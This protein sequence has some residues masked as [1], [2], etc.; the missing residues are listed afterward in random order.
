MIRKKIPLSKIC[1]MLIG[2]PWLFAGAEVTNTPAGPI[3]KI[4]LSK[5]WSGHSVGFSLLT[6]PPY[7]YAAYYDQDRNLVVASRRLDEKIWT[8]KILPTKLEWDSHNYVTMA[9]DNSGNLH[10]SGN[11]HVVPLIYFRT[12]KPRDIATLTS[13]AML[14]E[15]EQRVTYPQFVKLSNGD[16]LFSYR[17]GRSGEGDTLWNA[18]NDKTGRWTRQMDKALFDG[19]SQMSS[20]PSAPLLGPDGYF[21][22]T[23]VWRDTADCS[24]CHD[25][26]YARTRDFKNWETASGEKIALP[27]RLSSPGVV[28]DAIPVKGGIINGSGR[29]GFDRENRLVITYHKYDKDGNTQLYNARREKNEW[30]FYQT[31]SWNYRWN[32]SGGGS[33]VFEVRHG[34][35]KMENGETT[36]TFAHPKEGSGKWR[37]DPDTLTP[38][39]KIPGTPA[40]SFLGSYLGKVVS[41]F[42]GMEV[43]RAGDLGHPETPDVQYLLR[44]ESLPPNRDAP[45]EKPW[46]EPS[47]LVLYRIGP[48]P[49]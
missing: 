2:L 39:G 46:P 32:F 41:D 30:K 14:G 27:I 29:I 8:K 37:L 26:S 44:W 22:M 5:V 18:W 15:R 45:R 9:V 31:T 3:E 49:K 42:K 43:R 40:E 21:H 20:Y 12:A 17:D 47:D 33:I 48:A 4:A 38:L 1:S 10:V 36:L 19:E 24:T 6:D 23:W 35:V 25:L 7:Q 11:M 16:L 13:N 34:N 28:V